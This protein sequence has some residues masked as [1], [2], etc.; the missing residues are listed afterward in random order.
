MMVL[1]KT[2]KSSDLFGIYN[3]TEFSMLTLEVNV[4]VVS[5]T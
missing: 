1:D 3:F 5:K 4:W 2:T